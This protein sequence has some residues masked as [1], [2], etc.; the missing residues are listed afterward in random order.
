MA[1]KSK[2]INRMS[3][4]ELGEEVRSIQ[5]RI[6]DLR[7]QAVTEKIEDTSQF[8]KTRRQVARLLTE[9][10]ARQAKNMKKVAS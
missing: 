9:Q 2:D 5:R 7:T 10:T 6:F 4:E 8:R 3:D 1:R